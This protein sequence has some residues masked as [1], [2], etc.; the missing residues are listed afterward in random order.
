MSTVRGNGETGGVGYGEDVLTEGVNDVVP[1]QLP[2]FRKV[3]RHIG[4]CTDMSS[5]RGNGETGGVGD[6]EATAEGENSCKPYLYSRDCPVLR[7]QKSRLAT[8]TPL[9]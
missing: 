3:V 9:A 6:G 5:V 7:A 1:L 2:T 4:V 8:G